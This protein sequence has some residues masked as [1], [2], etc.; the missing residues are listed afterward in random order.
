MPIINFFSK[1]WLTICCA[2]AQQ[3]KSDED[4]RREANRAKRAEKKTTKLETKKDD[5]KKML[6]EVSLRQY[7]RDAR[8]IRRVISTCT[9]HDVQSIEP[10]DSYI[11]GY[12]VHF[13]PRAN[14]ASQHAYA[15]VDAKSDNSAIVFLYEPCSRAKVKYKAWWI[16][17]QEIRPL[18]EDRTLGYA[19][20]ILSPIATA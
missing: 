8:C 9:S 7:H 2:F 12:K 15:Y 6:E 3:I 18:V 4:L 19:K 16:Y 17:H 20:R 5:N 10:I 11:R 14:R 1:L 13:A